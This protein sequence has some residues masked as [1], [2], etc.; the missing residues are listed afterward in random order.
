MIKLGRSVQH[1]LMFIVHLDICQEGGF[2]GKCS[3]HNKKKRN[4]R[5]GWRVIVIPEHL[6]PL[7]FEGDES[8]EEISYLSVAWENSSI[9]MALAGLPLLQGGWPGPVA[10]LQDPACSACQGGG[11]LGL[12]SAEPPPHV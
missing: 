8:H 12:H 4:T 6:E 3:Y 7:G 1:C 2:P 10:W 9:G 5:S 11:L